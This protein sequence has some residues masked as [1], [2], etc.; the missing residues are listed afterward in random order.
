MAGIVDFDIVMRIYNKDESIT[1]AQ[2][3]S[4]EYR[5]QNTYFNIAVEAQ[6]YHVLDIFLFNLSYTR[7][8]FKV[9]SS[10]VELLIERKAFDV[11]LYLV[12]CYRRQKQWVNICISTLLLDTLLENYG[13]LHFKLREFL[14]MQ[15]DCRDLSDHLHT[16]FVSWNQD[17]V[18]L[19][20]YDTEL[21]DYETYCYNQWY[22]GRKQ[23]TVDSLILDHWDDFFQYCARIDNP[24]SGTRIVTL[25]LLNMIQ[26]NR[27]D[28]VINY[29][30]GHRFDPYCTFYLLKSLSIY[31]S[32]NW[33][34]DIDIESVL[35][36][37]SEHHRCILVWCYLYEEWR[38]SWNSITELSKAKQTV[39]NFYWTLNT[40]LSRVHAMCKLSQWFKKEYAIGGVVDKFLY[41]PPRGLMVRRGIQLCCGE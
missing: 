9:F 10:T 17:M 8:P 16:K 37:S 32:K 20:R 13:R 33:L 12:T 31:H 21:M 39:D 18:I 28:L 40:I 15:Y 29:V 2:L 19:N 41:A 36:I 6:N 34:G 23:E 5:I 1:V 22:I 25:I 3:Y 38:N 14:K 35:T 30:R 26:N 11:L 7:E 27:L 4:P 24:S